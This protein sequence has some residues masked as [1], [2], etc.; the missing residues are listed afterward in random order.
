MATIMIVLIL[1]VLKLAWIL[2]PIYS[3]TPGDVSKVFKYVNVV[4]EITLC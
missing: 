4:E 2:Q 1:F 3:V